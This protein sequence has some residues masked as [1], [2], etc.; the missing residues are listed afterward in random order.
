MAKKKKS[1]KTPKTLPTQAELIASTRRQEAYRPGQRFE[2]RKRA[3]QADATGRKA[4][5]KRKDDES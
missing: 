3:A 2:N 4:K 1:N 5:Y